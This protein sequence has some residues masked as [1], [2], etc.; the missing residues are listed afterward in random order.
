MFQT[1][2]AGEE[3]LGKIDIVGC[4]FD[5]RSWPGHVILSPHAEIRAEEN[6]PGDA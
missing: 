4:P 1:C 2:S 6:K 3:T 5:A